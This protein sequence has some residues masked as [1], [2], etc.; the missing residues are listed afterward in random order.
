MGDLVE[1]VEYRILT[2]DIPERDVALFS[3]II[4]SEWGDFFK[5]TEDVFLERLGKGG[6]FIG[7]Y[8]NF[9]PAGILETIGLDLKYPLDS[10][11]TNPK[12]I[13]RELCH[14]IG[15]YAE[16]TDGG[17]WRHHPKYTNTLVL[18]DIT[19]NPSIKNTSI[20]PGIVDYGKSLLLK[21]PS[22]RLEPLRHVK[23]VV[24]FTPNIDSI[25]R[26]HRKQWA[27]DTEF[28]LKDARLG[29]KEPDVNFMCYMSPGY[30][31]HLGQRELEIA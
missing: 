25:K 17:L 26:W 16:L 3:D 30:K 24:T 6:I 23:S 8:H 13:A 7:A 20:A 2:P 4:N 18:V 21:R 12:N 11:P 5:L 22:N 19:K 14:Q 10:I 9:S 1:K 28:L 15:N 31:P 29:Y 27:F